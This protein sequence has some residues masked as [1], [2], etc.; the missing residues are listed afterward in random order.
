LFTLVR[1]REWKHS[2]VIMMVF[3]LL[4]FNAVFASG[5]PA[6]ANLSKLARQKQEAD[7]FAAAESLRREAL[8]LAEQELEPAD[9]RL[10]PLLADLALTLHF[11]ARDAA[12]EPFAQRGLAIAKES[13]DQRLLASPLNV[14]GVVLSGE[15]Q[16][17]RA[18]PILRRSVSL[19]NENT[20]DYARAVNNLAILYLDTHQL[21][22]AETEMAAA[23][24][25]Y[26]KS[27]GPED[28][29]FALAL[30]NMFTI[31]AMDRRA[32]QGE[33]YLRQALSIGQKHFP[34]GLRMADLQLCLA[35]FE[36]S[37]EHL[38]EAARLLEKVIATQE[39]FLG[40][41]HP[42]LA[43]SLRAYAIV[44]RRMHQKSEAKNALNRA[45][46]IQKPSLNE[47]K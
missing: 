37:R 32:A 38:K 20:L 19:F 16:K 4:V 15:G 31:L 23:L 29:E 24:P 39:K 7:D 10:V 35:A 13:G 14:L 33:P 21:D 44:L 41:Q 11:E 28:P 30:S 8:R 5:Q 9:Q 42:E 47:L 6:W 26:E 1:P 22:K 34:E 40:P 3:L 45:N 12:A 2:V 17:A 18:E 36:A 27:V 43:H 46:M 25:A